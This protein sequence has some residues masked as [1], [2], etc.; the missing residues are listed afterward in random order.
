[1]PRHALFNRG[2][3]EI[4]PKKKSAFWGAG[5][6]LLESVEVRVRSAIFVSLL[7]N[8]AACAQ[9]DGLPGD[10]GADRPSAPSADGPVH[11]AEPLCT[12]DAAVSLNPADVDVLLVF[13]G[14]ESMGIGFG[15]GTRYSVLADVLSTLVDTYQSRIRFGFAQFPGVDGLC[16]GQ[17]VAGCCAGPPLVEVAP[18]NGAAVQEALKN[19]LPP[20]GSTPTASALLKAHEYYLGLDDGVVDHRYVLLATDGLPSCTLSGEIS[21]SQTAGGD[22]PTACQD[23]V[24]QV[25]ALADDGIKVVVLA[26]GAAPNDDPAGP[27]DCLDQMAQAGRMPRSLTGPGYYSAASPEYLEQTLE[28]IFGGVERTSCLI[29]LIPPPTSQAQVSVSLDD[30]EIPK[31]RDNGWG[32]DP[33]DGT[34]RIRIFGEYCSRIEHFR[35]S[36]IVAH[37]ACP[38]LCGDT[39]CP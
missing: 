26:V 30:Q 28:Q 35:Y 18:G 33:P 38:P 13:D 25:N 8:A 1:M 34:R 20:A 27:P 6:K 16:P 32:F 31:N 17:T 39:Y 11:E 14:S 2:R 7:A 19:L 12:T 23:A 3:A 9:Y 22:E 37:F 29:E 15:S 21:T 5:S 10:G 36:S 4:I 24:A